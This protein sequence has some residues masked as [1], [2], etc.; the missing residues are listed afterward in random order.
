MIWRVAIVLLVFALLQLYAGRSLA[1]S[2]RLVKVPVLIAWLITAALIVLPIF[3]ALAYRAGFIGIDSFWQ[4]TGMIAMGLASILF[5]ATLAG[6]LVRLGGSGARLLAGD[7]SP[8]TRASISRRADRVAA[9]GALTAALLTAGGLFVAWRP[10][11]V[12]EE[13]R[14]P[15]LDPRL[16]GM[17]I[18][19]LSD[20]HIGPLVSRTFASHVTA[21][22]NSLEPDLIAIAGDLVDGTPRVLRDH[23]APLGGMRARLG[24]FYVTGNHEYYWDAEGWI[25]EVRRLGWTVLEDEHRVLDL[26]GADLVIGGVHDL[27]AAS[28]IP[29]HR[30]DPAVAL[31]GA[32]PDLFTILLTHQPQSGRGASSL[33]VDLQLAGHTHG[34]QYFPFSL[35]VHLFQPMVRGLHLE[36]EMRIYITPGTGF[37]GPP[38][39]LGSRGRIVELTIRRA[40]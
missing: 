13:I 19:L 11:V 1:A 34:G 30:G 36:N 40:E 5:F 16:D 33:G 18:A 38:N 28:T 35:I 37:W 17:R 8:E 9:L 14:I 32:P 3:S 29:S 24:V 25:R 27:R 15:D 7:G 4:W 6:D 23:V 22:T 31:D 12:R 20:I 21:M 39:R 10:V 2:A 26:G